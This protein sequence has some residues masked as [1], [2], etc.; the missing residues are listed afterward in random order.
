MRLPLGLGRIQQLLSA[1]CTKKRA[2]AFAL[3]APAQKMMDQSWGPDAAS[4]MTGELHLQ[5]PKA[6]VF[7]PQDELWD[8]IYSDSIHPHGLP[9]AHFIAASQIHDIEVQ[10]GSI[11]PNCWF[12]SH[13]R[14]SKSVAVNSLPKLLGP[15]DRAS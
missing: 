9:E 4:P 2:S 12:S 10:Q 6:L 3:G 1:F 13:Q 7:F 14:S 15:L 8:I 11:I 5:C